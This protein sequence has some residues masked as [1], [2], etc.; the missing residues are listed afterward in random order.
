MT[1]YQKGYSAGLHGRAPTTDQPADYWAGFDDAI[2]DAGY[3][4]LLAAPEDVTH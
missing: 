4:M 1:D 2:D 3:L